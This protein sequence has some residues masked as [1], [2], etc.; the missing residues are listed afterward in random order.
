MSQKN[1]QEKLIEEI[2]LGIEER[3]NLSPIASRIYSLL[4]LSPYDGL[5]FEEI[6][7]IIQASKSSTSININVLS[8]LDY[9]KFY[10]KPGDRKRYFRLTKYSSLIS[11][12]MS[13]QTIGKEKEIVARINDYNK[14]YFPEKF[15]DDETLGH[16]F[17]D[18]L[19]EK[20]QLVEQTIKKMKQF[21][22]DESTS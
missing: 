12:E 19:I 17:E 21:R 1:D 2:G 15:T 9:I 16:I 10:T 6:R 5:T 11:L 18:Y 8:Q 7:D 4:I 13:L 22:Q 14:K 3:L 20:Q